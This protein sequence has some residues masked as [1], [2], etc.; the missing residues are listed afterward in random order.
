MGSTYAAERLEVAR[1]KETAAARTLFETFMSENG[2]PHATDSST[3]VA[4]AWNNV[5]PNRGFVGT[6]GRM[7]DVTV[8]PRPARNHA[9][10][11]AIREA[12]STSGRPILIPP[13]SPPS[14]L[15]TNVLIGWSSSAAQARLISSAIPLL[16]RADR[17]T[18]VT[19][20]DPKSQSVPI[21][22][23][24]VHYLR[25]NGIRATLLSCEAAGKPPAI[26]SILRLAGAYAYDLLIMAP[27]DRKLHQIFSGSM[28][29]NFLSEAS[30]AVLTGH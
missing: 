20:F 28:I 24:A 21:G 16:S 4:Y 18:V 22:E 15:G 5:L 30:V 14:S 27:S 23:Q 6:Y 29:R 25:R 7:F 12:L 9:R 26:Q 1:I 17:V 10:Y 11:L 3:S 2:V 8:L 19:M 13:S